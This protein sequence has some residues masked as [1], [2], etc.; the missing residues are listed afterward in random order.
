VLGAAS[1]GLAFGLLSLSHTPALQ[2]FG[3]TLLVGL[4]VVAVLAPALRASPAGLHEPRI[5]S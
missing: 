1:T 3:F 2:A 5:S 4:A